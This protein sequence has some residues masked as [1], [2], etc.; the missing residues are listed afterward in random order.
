MENEMYS[1]LRSRVPISQAGSLLYFQKGLRSQK[2]LHSIKY[3][4]AKD[5][6]ISSGKLIGQQFKDFILEEDVLV[7]VPLH[8]KKFN[9]RGY[10]QSELLCEGIAVV[11]KN[12]VV[13]DALSVAKN[14]SSQTKKNRLDRFKSREEQYQ[15]AKSGLIK[16]HR[17]WLID[18]VYTTG[19][20]AEACITELL[21][22]EPLEIGVLCLAFTA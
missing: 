13:T 2:L 21:R 22:A 9:K 17:V 12:R 18:D 1:S 19:A 5:L 15:L 6:A 11:C 7:P 10:N 16:N 20:T 14:K 4:S 3:K 8:T